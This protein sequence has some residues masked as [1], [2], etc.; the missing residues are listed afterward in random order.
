MRKKKKKK[1]KKQNKK[2]PES[3]MIWGEGESNKRGQL[4]FTINVEKG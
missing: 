4:F 3:M 1:K 2:V